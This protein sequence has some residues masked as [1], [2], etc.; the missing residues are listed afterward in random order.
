MKVTIKDIAREA[1]V[2]SGTVDRALHHR[3]GIKPEV[4]ERICRIAEEMNYQPN[5][6]ARTLVGK[7]YQ[8][9]H[10][11]GIILC[12]IGNMFFDDVLKGIHEELKQQQL[13]GITA[14]IREV[15][16][17][18][19]EKQ[20]EAITELEEQGIEGLVITPVNTIRIAQKIKM[21]QLRGIET[22]TIN[23]DLSEADN[24]AY[25]GSDYRKA[26]KVMGELLGL[27]SNKGKV[28]T[29]IVSGTTRAL[30][31]VERTQ[32]ILEMA[33]FYYRNVEVVKVIENEESDELSRELVLEELRRNREI[34]VICFVGGGVRGGL[35]AVKELGLEN[36][37]QIFTYDLTPIIQENLE[38]LVINAT[39]LQEPEVQGKCGVSI[40]CQ[41]IQQGKR[42]K[43]REHY[44]K[45][46][47]ATRYTQPL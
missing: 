37:L 29:L 23:T 24:L 7:R 46:H 15:K 35:S 8:K 44:T 3:G 11:I 32:G 5:V 43:K 34:D 45:C 17:F 40:I 1:G 6:V 38:K 30:A 12:S 4:A 20:L 42:P 16:G 28:H 41:Y 2:S 31:H 21:L 9:E 14:M 10:K 22:V 33:N 39:V 25:V 26:G 27:V 19:E 36:Q 47:I 18:D 13:L